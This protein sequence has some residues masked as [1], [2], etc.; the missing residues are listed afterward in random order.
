MTR[1]GAEI[2]RA[3]MRDVF[4]LCGPDAVTGARRVLAELT[5]RR[6]TETTPGGRSR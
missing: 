5:R 3:A 1:R 6:P 4:L 2:R